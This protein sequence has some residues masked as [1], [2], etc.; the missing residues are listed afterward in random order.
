M[1]ILFINI[2]FFNKVKKKN[3]KLF[4]ENFSKNNFFKKKDRLF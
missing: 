3:K 4:F 1:K 2:D